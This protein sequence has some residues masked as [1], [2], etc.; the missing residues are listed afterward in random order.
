MEDPCDVSY[1]T[2][3]SEISWYHNNLVLTIRYHPT[4]K[5]QSTISSAEGSS[6]SS[7]GQRET[8]LHGLELDR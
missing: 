1:G 4:D 5:T 7:P 6:V 2:M 8:V 3:K